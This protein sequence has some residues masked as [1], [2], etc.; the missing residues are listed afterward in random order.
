MMTFFLDYSRDKAVNIS[1]ISYSMFYTLQ[2]YLIVN[3]FCPKVFNPP[4]LHQA[5][6]PSAPQDRAPKSDE[7]GTVS[8]GPPTSPPVAPPPQQ[9]ATTHSTLQQ[10]AAEDVDVCS[11]YMAFNRF[12]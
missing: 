6:H 11:I 8:A 10:Q 12:V 3:M 4:G 1:K 7:G 5:G 9:P 2:M